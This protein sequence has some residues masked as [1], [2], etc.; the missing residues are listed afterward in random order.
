MHC[1]ISHWHIF[2][3]VIKASLYGICAS[4]EWIYLF[5]LGL[6]II[7]SEL[8]ISMC[9]VHNPCLYLLLQHPESIHKLI[10]WPSI[11]MHWPSILNNYSGSSKLLLCVLT[12]LSVDNYVVW[13]FHT[14]SV[15]KFY[16]L[17]TY[18]SSL[19]HLLKL[20]A[21]HR[22]VHGK[23]SE[24]LWQNTYTLGIR[25]NSVHTAA[26]CNGLAK[27]TSTF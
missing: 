5:S 21:L 3:T 27:T 14:W 23:L 24:V 20:T 13:Q 12:S 19:D 17:T 25:Q 6:M 9:C 18:L 4:N 15:N 7:K 22:P 1:S 2:Y 10:N 11:N 16:K 26:L 8:C